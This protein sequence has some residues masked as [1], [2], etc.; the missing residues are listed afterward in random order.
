VFVSVKYTENLQGAGRMIG[1]RKRKL[2]IDIL[3]VFSVLICLTVLCEILY[4]NYA[5]TKIVLKF[6]QDFYSERIT[7]TSVNS[8]DAY[9]E[10]L[11]DLINILAQI[12]KHEKEDVRVSNI[13]KFDRL[14]LESVKR[15]PFI[16]SIYVALSDGSYMQARTLEGISTYQKKKN[17]SLP[18]Y[19]KYALRKI[20]G[21]KGGNGKET[22]EYLNEDFGNVDTETLEAI[23]YDPR[24]RDWYVKTELA[25]RMV[26]SD[27]YI[28]ATSKLPGI[29]LSMPL[30]YDENEM[31][32]GNIA[33]DFALSHFKPILENVKISENTRCYLLNAKN[34]VLCQVG[35]GGEDRALYSI[36][37]SKDPVL[38]NA[39]KILFQAKTQHTMYEVK[40]EA[41]LASLRQLPQKRI[42]LLL[43]TPQSDILT[44]FDSVQSSMLYISFF[45]FLLSFVVVF[46]LSKRISKPIGQICRTARAIGNMELDD[47]PNAPKSSILEI[48]DLANS[49]EKMRV[50]VSTFA[51]YA[52]KELVRKMITSGTTPELGGRT[53]Q[54]TILF[55]DIEKFSTISENLPAEYL[56]LHMSEYFSELTTTIMDNSGMIDKYIGDSI[57]AIWGAPIRDDN[58]VVNACYAALDC[59]TVLEELKIKWEPMGKPPLP[60]RIGLHTGHAIVGNIGSPDRLSFTAIGDSVNVASRLEG[61]NKIYGTKILVSEDVESIA[62][63][64]ILFR[65]IDKVEVVGKTK[66]IIIYEPLCSM[67]DQENSEYYGYIDLCAK[68][69]EAFELYQAQKFKEAKK[70]YS[71]IR[72]TYPHKSSAIFPIMNR[73]EMYIK[74]PPIEWNGTLKLTSK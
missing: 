63:G 54:I 43:I 33:I 44:E 36:M 22:W 10:E 62:H 61:V 5:N 31:T 49:I 26:W 27:E 71:E 40:G 11:E 45:V 68:S 51:K 12:Y 7:T 2:Y 73:C 3:A 17:K 42:S 67:K 47:V 55:S 21:S 30:G 9:F 4:S 19:A 38:M 16:T 39:A 53:E 52:P 37:E 14:F 70:I 57:M 28:Y 50:G 74:D 24:K 25:H 29:T 23:S 64:K 65:V 59:Q 13:A 46:L 1:L 41:Y 32:V 48:N 35:E 69:K 18:S 56:I 72:G 8:I 66:G 58:Q 60:T 34:E 15:M 6:E 20:H